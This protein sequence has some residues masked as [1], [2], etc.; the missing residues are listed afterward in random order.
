MLDAQDMQKWE[1]F[2]KR[3]SIEKVQKMTL[4]E[5]SKAKKNQTNENEDSLLT[6]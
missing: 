1:E 6:G 3:W 2:Q 4:E 5:Y